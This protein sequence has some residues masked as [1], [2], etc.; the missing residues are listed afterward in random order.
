[1]HDRH[2]TGVL[3]MVSGLWVGVLCRGHDGVQPSDRRFP[4]RKY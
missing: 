3:I 2:V 1:M 4:I